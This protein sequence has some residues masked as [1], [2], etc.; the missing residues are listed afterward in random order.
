[1]PVCRFMFLVFMSFVCKSNTVSFKLYLP[2]NSSRRQTNFGRQ[3]TSQ[4]QSNV[5]IKMSDHGILL[6]FHITFSR[7][8]LLSI[9]NGSEDRS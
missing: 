5:I 3:Q 8:F 4:K 1:M 2:F 7:F 9:I 6:M